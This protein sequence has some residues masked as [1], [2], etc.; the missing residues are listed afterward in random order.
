MPSTRP[1]QRYND[2]LCNVEAIGRYVAG[3]NEH[4]F[5]ADPKTQDASMLCLLRIS[6]AARKLGPVA[7]E[8]IKRIHAGIDRDFPPTEIPQGRR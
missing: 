4:Q 2:I 6:E 8:S 3:M 5:L 7:E 1:L